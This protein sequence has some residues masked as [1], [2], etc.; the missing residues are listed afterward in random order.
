MTGTLDIID[1]SH[2]QDG[3][4]PR[5]A[6]VDW[7][8]VLTDNRVRGIMVKADQTGKDPEWD[9]NWHTLRNL[10]PNPTGR[11]GAPLLFA[12]HFHTNEDAALQAQR[13]YNVV[14]P[15]RPGE[16]V[17]VDFEAVPKMGIQEG[18]P[19]EQARLLSEVERLFHRKPFRYSGDRPPNVLTAPWPRHTARYRNEV[20]DYPCSI[21]QF[22]SAVVPGIDGLVDANYV[23]D[24]P[25]VYRCCGLNEEDDMTKEEHD[26]LEAVY[27]LMS[28]G[29]TGYGVQPVAP[30]VS[31]IGRMVRNMA[32]KLGVQVEPAN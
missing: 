29:A 12:Y 31:R 21:W 19:S 2:F 9:Y 26:W 18:T 3:D 28:T 30:E 24:W 17:M 1:V 23:F 27:T 13:F 5:H 20:P 32:V 11:P 4:H 14:G 15:L 10:V 22:G 6:L 16:G 8:E 25:T 7:D